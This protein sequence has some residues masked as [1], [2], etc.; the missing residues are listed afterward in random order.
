MTHSSYCTRASQRYFYGIAVRAIAFGIAAFGLLHPG[1][2]RSAEDY[3]IWALDQ[4]THVVHIFNS[5]LEEVARIDMTAHG[6][7]VPHMIDFTSDHA[8]AAV[9]STA[10]GDV[11]MIRTKDRAVVDV[12]KTGPGT[13]MAVV[14]PNDSTI[15]ADLI[16][17]PKV[18]NDGKLVEITA[19]LQ[20]GAFKIARSL[21]IADDPLFKASSDKFGD[22]GAV[23]H[24]YTADGRYAYVTLGPALKDGG[25]V[26]LDTQSF[27]LVAAYPPSELKVNC[28]TVL[29]P[30]G[31]HMFVNGGSADTGVWYALNTTTHKVVRQGESRGHDAHGTWVTPDGREVWMVNRVTSNGIVIDP[32]TLEVRAE[33]TDIG[34][35]PD[36]IAMSPDSRF[37]FITLRGPNPV[38]APHVAKGKTPGFAVVDIAQRKLVKVVQPA[39]GNDKSDFHGIGV[40]VIR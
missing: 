11:T 23:C 15:I 14:M 34:P 22:V 30:D 21:V 7:K 5:K 28:G 24:E 40:R 29:T 37:A 3:E 10:S 6:V 36:I 20:N 25:L 18:P 33:L 38:T 1:V 16:G 8:Y 35:T 17:D 2:A 27:T 32:G 12:L 31:K 13:H 19:D 26:V 9:A 39:E 4:G